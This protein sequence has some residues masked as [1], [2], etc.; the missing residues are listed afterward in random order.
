MR[1]DDAAGNDNKDDG[2][3]EGGTLRGHDGRRA[4]NAL[5]ARVDWLLRGPG[6]A[7]VPR[8]VPRSV[9]PGKGNRW[10]IGKWHSEPEPLSGNHAMWG[11]EHCPRHSTEKSW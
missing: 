4:R 7:A 3:N 10:W 1:R 11:E 2:S 6:R 5:N 9:P 8:P